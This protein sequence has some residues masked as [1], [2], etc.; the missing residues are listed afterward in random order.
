MLQPNQALYKTLRERYRTY[1]RE[2]EEGVE[3]DR[4]LQRSHG[5]YLLCGE[6]WVS[7][8]SSSSFDLKEKMSKFFTENRRRYSPDLRSQWTMNTTISLHIYNNK[9]TCA[10]ADL[11]LLLF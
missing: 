9:S 10:D 11:L 7:S 3:G 4:E 6:N 1:Q 2:E 5:F 8:S